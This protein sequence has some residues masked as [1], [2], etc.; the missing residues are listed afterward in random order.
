MT[1]AFGLRVHDVFHV[2][3]LKRYHETPED[4]RRKQ[5][6]TLPPK[7]L[8]VDGEL[9]YEVEVIYEHKDVISKRHKQ[10]WYHVGWKGLSTDFNSWEPEKNL[11]NCTELMRWYWKDRPDKA[12]APSGLFPPEVSKPKKT[13]ESPPLPP[14]SESQTV[15]K[16][17]RSVKPP[18]RFNALLA[19][20][21]TAGG[22]ALLNHHWGW[23]QSQGAR[24]P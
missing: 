19:H 7:P 11:T 10:R 5:W 15:T 13:R 6:R 17:G 4:A 21:C 16:R 12:D 2:S 3:L 1:K 23:A 14:P 20:L 18:I 9:E 8:V 22:C 24:K